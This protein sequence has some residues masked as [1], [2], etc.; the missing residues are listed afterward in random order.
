MPKYAA[1]REIT[2]PKLDVGAPAPAVGDTVRPKL[3]KVPLAS[4][5][6]GQGL[7]RKK[8]RLM[9]APPTGGQEQQKKEE[10][11]RALLERS[12]KVFGAMEAPILETAQKACDVMKVIG[13]P[14]GAVETRR[15]SSDSESGI[16]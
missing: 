2:E 16:G 8:K 1:P 3:T 11:A 6:T 5:G 9:R 10:K 4:W 14:K 13:G 15:A 7:R 12:R